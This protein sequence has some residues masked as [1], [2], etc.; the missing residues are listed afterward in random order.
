MLGQQRS[1]QAETNVSEHEGLAVVI[2]PVSMLET[3]AS[4]HEASF[5]PS[6]I[7]ALSRKSLRVMTPPTSP[8]R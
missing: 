7:V 2:C 1:F 6:A 4:G 3:R 5:G 8:P